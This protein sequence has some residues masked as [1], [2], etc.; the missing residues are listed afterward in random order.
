M[1]PHSSWRRFRRQ[2]SAQARDLRILLKQFGWSILG[3]NLLIATG[4][5]ALQRFHS[6]PVDFWQ[7]CY[8]MFTLIFFQPELDFPPANEPGLRFMFFAVP[9]V[10]LGF[11]AEGLLRFGVLLFNKSMRGEKWQVVLAST[12]SNHI[13]LCGLGHVGYRIA[14]ELHQLGEDFVC[15]ARESKFIEYIKRLDIPV[16]VG[17]ARDE[18][19]MESL[20]VTRA[21]AIIIATDDDLANLE[22]AINARSRNPGIRIVVRMFDP[23]LAQKVQSA[24]GIHL[25]FSTSHLAAPA[26][27]LAAVDKRVMHSFYVG[28]ELLNVV[29]LEVEPGSRYVGKTLEEFEADALV[30]VVVHRR[31][32]AAQPHPAASVTLQ[33]QDMLTLL[34]SVKTLGELGRHG[35][36]SVAIQ[37]SR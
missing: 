25:A 8:A 36:K 28:D 19:L 3:F 13:I 27:A 7:G 17:D 5:W 11:L 20:N 29:E 30:T 1:K 24:F 23:E 31:G 10:G 34:C 18:L 9:L 15:V 32:E 33:A 16:L 22:T 26:V 14:Q 2:I 37:V 4:G 35:M 21:K 12:Y 6:P